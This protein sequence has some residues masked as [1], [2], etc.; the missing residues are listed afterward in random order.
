MSAVPVARFPIDIVVGDLADPQSV[1]AAVDGCAFVFNC[2]KGK[3]ADAAR[4]RAVDVDGAAHVVSAARGSGARV[5]HVSTMAVYDRPANGVFD[6][7]AP[8]VPRGDLYSDAKLDGERA[9]LAM[10]ARY[11]VPVVVVQPA[12]IYGPC[13]G[14]VFETLAELRTSRVILVNG[15]RGICN[16]VYV[17]DVAT[18]LL[19]ASTSDRAPGERFLCS[20][21][22]HP[23][24]ADFVGAFERMLGVRRTVSLTEEEAM[25]LWRR[26]RRRPW[27]LGETLRAL[28]DDAPLR[29]R[30]I[31]T[32]EGV[33]ARWLA[34]RILPGTVVHATR[35]A[36]RPP[37]LAAEDAEA[38]LEPIRPW[39]VRNMARRARVSIEKSQRVLGFTPAFALDRGMRLTEL[40]ARWAGLIPDG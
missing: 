10:G 12:I 11:G 14:N 17:D 1:N 15:G 21:P 37:P 3:G 26:G 19:L 30:L 16:L 7:S 20:G 6:E 40:W 4:R 28:R 18:M 22:E 2:A 32:R 34:S 24:W 27:L 25:E 31:A 39:V 23:T 29:A 8:D 33:T 13:A 38:P 36:V 5:V 35:H 9:A